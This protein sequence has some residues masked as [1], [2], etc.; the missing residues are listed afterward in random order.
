M[1]RLSGVT[2]SEVLQCSYEGWLVYEA[3]RCRK[4]HERLKRCR[5]SVS[6]TVYQYN[7]IFYA[8]RGKTVLFSIHG[9]L[10]CVV[11]LFI[12]HYLLFFLFIYSFVL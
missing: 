2:N 10:E 1:L 7:V 12:F 5:I 11:F 8:Q 9:V 3:G 4:G 6:M